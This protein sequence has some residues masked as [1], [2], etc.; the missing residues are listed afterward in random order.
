MS[1]NSSQT[2]HVNDN[3]D[4]CEREKF[5][6]AESQWW[7]PEGEFGALHRINPL[8]LNF[9]NERTPLSGK[10]VCDV[11]CGGG[12]LSEAMASLGAKVTGIDIS[13][14]ILDVA[15]SH[16]RTLEQKID[17]RCIAVEEL[18]QTSHGQWDV[19]TCME[20]LEHVPDPGSIVESC[21]KLIKP[22]GSIYF[23]TFNRN[24]KSFVQAIVGAEY[25]LGL[26]PK[27]TH[28]YSKFI[29]PYELLK[30]CEKCN[31]YLTD[32]KGISYNPFLNRYSLAKS[33]DVNYIARAACP[34]AM[35]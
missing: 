30:W 31:V 34:T 20:A 24:I 17:Y 6:V 32:I 14:E 7:N 12:I 15:R 10:T 8:R 26:L 18:A 28:D 16:A 25:I 19:V 5:E 21:A 23:S 1:I 9:I 3:V 4:S 22:G 29:R 2:V 33:V 35:A 27:G 11:G 13:E